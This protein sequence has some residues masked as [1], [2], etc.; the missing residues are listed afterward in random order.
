MLHGLDS[1]SPFFLQEAFLVAVAFCT[2][3]H[4][5]KCLNPIRKNCGI[6]FAVESDLPSQAQVPYPGQQRLKSFSYLSGISG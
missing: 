4:R 2:A 5:P 3:P 6:N 1:G